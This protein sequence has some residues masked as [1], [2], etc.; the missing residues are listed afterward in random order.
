MTCVGSTPGGGTLFRYVTNHSGRLSLLPP[1]DGKM[2]TSQRAMMFCSWEVKAAM[3][4]NLQVKLCDP[5]LSA[6][7]ALCGKTCYTNRRI[8]YFRIHLRCSG[9]FSSQSQ[10]IEVL[11]CTCLRS[12]V[13]SHREAGVPRVI[14]LLRRRRKRRVADDGKPVDDSWHRSVVH[15]LRGD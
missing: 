5:C 11:N 15:R 12:P 6:F 2:S 3:A 8:L 9:V 13:V 4:Y 1:W 14:R 7:E 10:T